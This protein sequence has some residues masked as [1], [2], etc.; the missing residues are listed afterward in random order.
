MIIPF[1]LHGQ[2]GYMAADAHTAE[3]LLAPRTGKLIEPLTSTARRRCFP[4]GFTYYKTQMCHV[5]EMSNMQYVHN[6]SLT[7]TIIVLY[8]TPTP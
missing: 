7:I 2:H 4:V 3:M 6:T 1:S 8:C 5:G